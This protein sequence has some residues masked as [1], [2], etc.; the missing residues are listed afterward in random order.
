MTVQVPDII[1]TN[2]LSIILD[3]FREKYGRL[4]RVGRLNGLLIVDQD[5]KVLAVN[6]FFDTNL[7]YWDIGAIGAALYGVSKQ[8]R[9][10]LSAGN[11]DRA[12]MIYASKQFFV[13]NIGDIQL[14]DGRIREL[15]LI[16]LG[17]VKMNIG[18]VVMQMRRL[19]PKILDQVRTD[20]RMQEV[21]QMS[22]KELCRHLEAIRK[23]MFLYDTSSTS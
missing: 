4:S 9:D 1:R 18:L 10:F 7:N 19:A 11:L 22:E 21:M 20:S 6:Q 16:A 23:E 2:K 14:P 5:A 17:D 13:Q 3:T 8:G 12:T 15:I